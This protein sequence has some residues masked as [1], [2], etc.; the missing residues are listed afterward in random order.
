MY[1][2]VW[3]YGND[4][5]AL[6]SRNVDLVASVIDLPIDKH[7]DMV[8]TLA[9]GGEFMWSWWTITKTED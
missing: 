4:R 3:H 9:N 7:E 8:C 6:E 2:A 5:R 1:R